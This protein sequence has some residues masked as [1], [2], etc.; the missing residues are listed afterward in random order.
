MN[1]KEKRRIS[2]TTNPGSKISMIF[3]ADCK[4]NLRDCWDKIKYQNLIKMF[5]FKITSIV[6]S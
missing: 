1:T 6:V 2:E 5:L 4:E 3:F